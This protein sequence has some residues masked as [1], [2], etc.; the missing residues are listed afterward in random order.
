VINEIG[1]LLEGGFHEIV[2]TGIHT[3]GYGRDLEGYDF[4]DLIEEILATYPKLFR[5]RISSI[6]ASE[7]SERF[8]DMLAN[9]TRLAHHLHIP[10]QA[11]SDHVLKA[12]NRHYTVTQFIEKVEYI[13]S[14][15]PDIAITT[16]IIV[17]FPGETD[18]DFL[19]TYN[20]SKHLAFAKIHVFPYSPRQGTYAATLKD[21]V[22]GNV[23]KQRVHRLLE[24]SQQ[25]ESFYA[26]MFEGKALD[27]II[28]QYDHQHEAYEG[29][30][31]NYL[32]VFVTG[33]DLARNQIVRAVFHSDMRAERI[34]ETIIR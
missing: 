22:D 18:F 29:H 2:L 6:E 19:E 9:D 23:K 14:R 10:L 7:I 32:K 20:V 33:D 5:L 11:G 25:L 28:E 15:L 4:D 30:S 27:I 17:G 34:V 8:I 13:K 31:S 21:E 1:Q 26:Q 12:M 16:D 24:L 3:A